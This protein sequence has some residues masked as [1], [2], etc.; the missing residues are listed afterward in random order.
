MSV[1]DR[2]GNPDF[3]QDLKLDP[4]QGQDSDPDPYDRYPEPD[5]DPYQD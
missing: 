3:C 1:I 2:G 5:P 4:Y